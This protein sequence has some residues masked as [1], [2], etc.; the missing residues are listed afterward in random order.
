M[1]VAAENP[2]FVVDR[3]ARTPDGMMRLVELAELLQAGVIDEGSRMNFPSRHPLNQTQRAR[4]AVAEADVVVGLESADF[5]GT[6]NA[7]R[8][9]LHRSTQASRQGQREADHNHH[10]RPVHPRQLPGLPAPAGRR[11]CDCG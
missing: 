11:P 8:D 2:V 7:V 5:W 3:L 10:G 4:A 9:Q 1:L 6:I